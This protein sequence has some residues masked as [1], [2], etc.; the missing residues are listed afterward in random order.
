[1]QRKT[2]N[3]LSCEVKSDVIIRQSNFE[4]DDMSISFCPVC[5]ADI[6]DIEDY[7]PEDEWDDE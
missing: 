5:S 2:I 3:C 6:D 7:I 1:M 4:D